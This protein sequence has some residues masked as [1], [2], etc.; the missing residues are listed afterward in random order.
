[1]SVIYFSDKELSEVY[2]KLSFF[3]AQN[4]FFVDIG[5]AELEEFLVRVGLCNRLAYEY[6]YHRKD[7]D[8]IVLK[9][10][11]VEVS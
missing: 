10:P 5:E 2:G 4:Y 9:I 1:M 8:K 3:V 6:N 7:S 11:K